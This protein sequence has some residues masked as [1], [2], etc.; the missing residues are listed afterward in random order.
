MIFY[1]E[2]MHNYVVFDVHPTQ[3][4]V[5]RLL[6]SKKSIFIYINIVFPIALSYIF[7]Y[8]LYFIY[9]FGIH[10]GINR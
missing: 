1:I 7:I 10:K 6:N 5:N 9:T 4:L 8:I 3:L 2:I